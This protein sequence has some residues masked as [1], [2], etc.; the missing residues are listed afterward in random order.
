M[1][2]DA[3]YR[4]PMKRIL[5]YVDG[6]QYAVG[7]NL[8]AGDFMRITEFCASE[9]NNYRE[10]IARIVHQKVRVEA[11]VPLLSFEQMWSLPDQIFQG[12]IEG[13]LVRNEGYRIA[14]D[15]LNDIRDPYERF[16]RAV[17][18]YATD[19]ITAAL[20]SVDWNPAIEKLAEQRQ[21]VQEIAEKVMFPAL[22]SI[23]RYTKKLVESSI[24]PISAAI[25]KL[26][27][28]VTELQTPA[29]TDSEKDDLIA[30]Y[31][32]WGAFGWTMA[33]EMI[34]G[35][36]DE[37]PADRKTANKAA[38]AFCTKKEMRRL[39]GELREME[40]IKHTDLEEAIFD[41]E[42]RK[43]KSCIMIVYSLLDGKLIKM[44]RKEN[45]GGRR[46]SR[47]EGMRPS[48]ATAGAN[49]INRILNLPQEHQSLLLT[50]MCTNLL[51]CLKELFK[52]GDDFIKQPE[53]ANR[54]FISH[55]MLTRSV[56]RMDCVKA[57]LLYYNLLQLINW[58]L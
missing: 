54:H 23:A 48:G 5:F 50:L 35:F 58:K 47:G 28:A 13:V 44:Q 6:V 9:Q 1:S 18:K 31:Q 4:Q 37:A 26:G 29:L 8:S 19:N 21:K 15:Q 57:F 39:F 22:E 40:G 16:A 42:H 45:R 51:S 34:F 30:S 17:E 49:V 3:E 20:K 46:N 25:E 2:E 43:Y 27:K 32:K 36:F 10:V 7:C 55:G 11:D 53:E 56:K 14:Y 12:Y 24:G 33:P 38:L 41:F 52:L